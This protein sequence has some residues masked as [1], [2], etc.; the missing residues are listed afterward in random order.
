[1]NRLRAVHRWLTAPSRRFVPLFFVYLWILT[2]L[3]GR[4]PRSAIE[5]LLEPTA[6]IDSRLLGLF[7]DRVQHS[8]IVVTL[9]G[10]AVQIITECVGLFESVI[11]AA[12]VL[13]YPATWRERVLGVALG[14]AALYLLNV[15][16]I[17]FLLV[18]GRHAPAFFEFAH[19]YLWQ[20]L[21]ALFI[22][23][24]WLAWIRFFVRTEVEAV[25][26]SPAPRA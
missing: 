12:A 8:G 15:L 2:T 19:V 7:S 16:R 21:L 26:T 14:T 6:W 17:A 13:A 9:D 22:A 3:A 4:L 25:E 1:M 20:T 5:R 11:L 23:P 24:L 10:F 18:V